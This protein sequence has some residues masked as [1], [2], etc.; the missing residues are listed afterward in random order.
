MYTYL[1]SGLLVAPRE[2]VLHGLVPGMYWAHLWPLLMSMHLVATPNPVYNCLWQQFKFLPNVFCYL[3]GFSLMYKWT[4][5]QWY[6]IQ[7][8]HLSTSHYYYYSCSS[9]H[10]FHSSGQA[11]CPPFPLSDTQWLLKYP[12]TK[13][14]L[15]RGWYSSVSKIALP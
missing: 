15:K 3:D 9:L 4:S 1:N 5:Q 8:T 13:M 11:D 2:Y 12:S 10:F 14:P 6:M 7:G